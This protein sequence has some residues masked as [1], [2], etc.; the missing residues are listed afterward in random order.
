[1]GVGI[2]SFERDREA[3]AALERHHVDMV[4]ALAKRVDELLAALSDAVTGERT[5]DEAEAA[6]TSVSTWCEQE[7]VPHGR[8]LE[9]ALYPVGFADPRGALLVEGLLAEHEL[10]RDL[11]D[12]VRTDEDLVS[13]AAAAASTLR[14]FAGTAAKADE[15]LLPL[16]TSSPHVSLADLVEGLR[17]PVPEQRTGRRER[18]V[19]R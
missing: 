12:E 11:V 9:K 19:N 8:A 7:L 4:E 18:L 5:P 2:I 17:E 1:M 10:V 3:A 13:A 15:L 16:L 14:V 6:R